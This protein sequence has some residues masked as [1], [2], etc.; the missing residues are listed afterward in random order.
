MNRLSSWNW[1][2]A[3]ALTLGLSGTAAHCQE[4]AAKRVLFF[5]DSITA[6]FGPTDWPTL[7]GQRRPSLQICRNGVPARTTVDGLN[8]FDGVMA[9]TQLYG[10]VTDVVILLGINDLQVLGSDSYDTAV[11]LRELGER[12]RAWGAREWILTL[13]PA[14]KIPLRRDLPAWEFSRDVGNWL[15]TLNGIG[16]AYNIIDVRDEF[17]RRLLWSSCSTDGL[18]PTGLGCRQVIADVVAKALP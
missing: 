18:H 14:L 16:P 10:R 3:L 1:S 13:T 17:G 8:S 9:Y 11:R 15:L 4:P 6:W 7:V 12:V 2:L 5:G